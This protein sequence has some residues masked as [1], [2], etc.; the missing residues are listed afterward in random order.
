MRLEVLEALRRLGKSYYTVADL[1]KATGLAKGS[2]YVFLARWTKAGLLR[3]LGTGLYGLPDV[4]PDLERLGNECCFPSYLSFESALARYGILSQVPYVLT[5]ATPRRSR[6]LKLTGTEIEY[7]QLRPE[8]F[9]GYEPQNGVYVALPEKAL[10]DQLY[11]KGLGRAELDAS[12]L[13][14]KPV[15][16][17][18]LAE[19]VRRFPATTRRLAAE[20]VGSRRTAAVRGV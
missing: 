11:M 10:C 20:L 16:R 14:L 15:R 13:N 5:F 19:F 7:R 18:V 9:F 12:G 17:R 3:R 1:G 6:R 2:L 8:L 4:A